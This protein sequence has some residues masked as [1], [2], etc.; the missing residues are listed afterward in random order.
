MA[1]AA[2]GAHYYSFIYNDAEKGEYHYRRALELVDRV[3][4]RER[5]IIETEFA[6]HR[7]HL[8]EAR[9]LYRAYLTL[10]P[11]DLGMQQGLAKLLMG[12]EHYE[13]AIAAY[14][15]VLR[16][17]P[18]DPAANVD[19]GACQAGVGN[20]QIAAE[21]YEKAFAIEPSWRT[22]GNINHEYGFYQVRLGRKDA[23]RATFEDAM[24]VSPESH[25]PHRSLGLLLL[26]EGKLGAA[27]GEFDQAIKLSDRQD[28]SLSCSRNYSFAALTSRWQ[29][30]TERRIE[31]LARAA[32][33]LE[34]Q[35]PQPLWWVRVGIEQARC[36]E[37]ASAE[38]A[39]AKVE[40]QSDPKNERHR[41]DLLRLRGEILVAT[42]DFA[43]GIELLEEA[44]R[45]RAGV[46]GWESI[47][48]AQL[49]YGRREDA[50]VALRNFI[51][52]PL[53]PIG[54]EPQLRWQ[55]AHVRL[56]AIDLEKGERASAAALLDSV[57]GAWSDA[58][59]DF[60]LAIEAR[61]MRQ[62]I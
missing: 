47:A 57:L 33:Y 7:D 28:L 23:A 55:E 61:E 11:D 36:G 30:N 62:G 12:G 41:A 20:F 25:Q 51:D 21:S 6:A 50:A 24:A 34:G 13:E 54:F 60:T 53:S 52:A 59:G 31:E 18:N 10:Y 29:G 26:Y 46:A 35:G 15:E 40:E 22:W 8:D 19:Y 45:L 27:R 4:D 48:F 49:Q 37:I 5:R 38:R 9:R 39:L 16:I 3:T 14:T 32:Q 42:D 43:G 44:M 2:L 56:A 58:D 1:H 17:E